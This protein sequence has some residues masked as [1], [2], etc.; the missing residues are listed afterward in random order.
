MSLADSQVHALV[1]QC[2]ATRKR[3]SVKD[4]LL[5]Y[6]LGATVVLPH[7]DDGAMRT[8]RSNALRRVTS[9]SPDMTSL[10]RPRVDL[11]LLTKRSYQERRFR[12]DLDLHKK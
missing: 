1:A 7:R 10:Q 8:S 3:P 9:K 4:K 5:Q 12:D 2:G 6:Q 11:A